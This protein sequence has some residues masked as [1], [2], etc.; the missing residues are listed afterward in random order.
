MSHIRKKFYQSLM[1]AGTIAILTGALCYSVIWISAEIG[2]R[3]ALQEVQATVSSAISVSTS[4]TIP[5]ESQA[6]EPAPV[7]NTNRFAK[8]QEQAKDI[9]AQMNLTEKIGQLFLIDLAETEPQQEISLYQ[10]AG[11]IL[12]AKDVAE[13]TPDTLRALLQQLNSYSKIPLAVATDEEGGEIVR[14]SKY[15][16]FRDSPFSSPQT[17]FQQGGVDSLAADASEKS[18]FLLDLGINLNLSPVCDVSQDPQNYIYN[19]TLGV[20]ATETAMSIAVVVQSME[21]A[22]IS[23]ALKHF[24]GYGPNPDSHTGSVTD[25]RS[26]DDFTEQDFL[27]F[28]AGIEAGAEVVLVSHNI[29]TAFDPEY[30]ASLSPEIHR[31]LREELNFTG[32]IMT[33][34]LAMEATAA[35]GEE[36]VLL[37]FQAGNNLILTREP[38]TAVGVIQSAIEEGII[39]EDMLDQAILP[40]I[41]WKLEKG[42]FPHGD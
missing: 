8:T 19:R 41:A 16:A 18:R 21:N 35:F 28:Q 42:I 30:P 29:V 36:A 4:D 2:Q 37:A 40:T 34:D 13:L 7:E 25:T 32:L 39:T 23:C 9:L 3:S 33:D 26:R 38:D 31:I 15:P 6:D 27:P 24:P 1:I 12:F 14:I 17:L 10:P 20:D 11:I 5:G 22:G